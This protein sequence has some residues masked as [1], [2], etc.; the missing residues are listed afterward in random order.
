TYISENCSKL[1]LEGLMTVGPLAGDE[2]QIRSAFSLLRG[3][4][5]KIEKDLDRPLPV[6]SMGMSDDF[7][8]AVE[9]GSTLVRIGSALFG[10]REYN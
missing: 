9:E 3:L 5:S 8:W 7:H 10:V 1:S 4:L 2:K 6:L